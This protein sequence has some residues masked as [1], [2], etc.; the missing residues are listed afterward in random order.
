[1]ICCGGAYV[2][3]IWKGHKDGCFSYNSAGSASFWMVVSNKVTKACGI[4]Y[5]KIY[6]GFSSKEQ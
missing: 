3:P 2:H 6:N 4:I 5:F 1:M